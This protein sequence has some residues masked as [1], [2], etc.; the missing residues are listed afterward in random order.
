MHVGDT[1][2]EKEEQIEDRV[3]KQYE[4]DEGL[5]ISDFDGFMGGN[6]FV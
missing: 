6:P 1:F 3:I 5:I 4:R 2:L